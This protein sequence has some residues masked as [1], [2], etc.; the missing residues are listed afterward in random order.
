[1]MHLVK[2]TVTRIGVYWRVLTGSDRV[3]SEMHDEMQF[4]VEM[5]TERLMR[6]QGLS[7]REARRVRSCAR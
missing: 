1:M 3:A 6:Q 5:E 4:H 7:P 2:R